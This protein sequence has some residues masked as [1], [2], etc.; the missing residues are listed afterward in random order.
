[1]FSPYFQT[2]LRTNAAAVAQMVP[3]IP[4]S[5]NELT[6]AQRADLASELGYSKIGK[7]L[8]DTVTLN[9]VVRSMPPEVRCLNP[10]LFLFPLRD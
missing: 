10:F 9:D 6:D 2:L 1:M 4:A 7:E 3:T 5:M 8:P